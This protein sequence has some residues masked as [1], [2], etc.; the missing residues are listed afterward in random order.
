MEN[1]AI[2]KEGIYEW[3]VIMGGTRHALS[4]DVARDF[5][6]WNITRER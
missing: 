4:S 5:M 6:A 3:Y 1:G 2:F